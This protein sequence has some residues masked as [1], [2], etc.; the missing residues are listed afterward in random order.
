[1]IEERWMGRTD[2]LIPTIR[3]EPRLE[4]ANL[5]ESEMA[6]FFEG[7]QSCAPKELDDAAVDTGP[8]ML[9]R[10]DACIARIGEENITNGL[11]KALRR[12][13]IPSTD[14]WSMVRS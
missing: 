4:S 14:D 2:F 10:P 8:S 12:W 5:H 13:F 3:S 7:T 1:V 6:L 9:I 11:E